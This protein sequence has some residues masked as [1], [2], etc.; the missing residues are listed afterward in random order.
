MRKRK[1]SLLLVLAL[2]VSLVM[3]VPAGAAEVHLSGGRSNPY[4]PG[5]V[6]PELP[7]TQFQGTAARRKAASYVSPEEAA[8][9][10]RDAMVRRESSVTLY[11]AT[12]RFWYQEDD[13]GSLGGNWFDDEFFPM[14]YSQELA[15]GLYD[16]DY[17]KWSW[18]QYQWEMETVS[19]GRYIFT[20]TGISYYT[21]Y[22]EEQ[23]LDKK[24]RA[25]VDALGVTAMSDYEAYKTLYD[26]VTK[27]VTFDYEGMSG[28][29]ENRDYYSYTAYKALMEGTAVCQGYATLY[30]AM[31]RYAKL[32]CRI[33]TSQDH[34]WNI[35]Y[36]KH[37]WYNLDSTWDA[38]QDWEYFLQGSENFTKNVSHISENEYLTDAFQSA[39]PISPKDYDGGTPFHDVDPSMWSY[40]EIKEATE[41]G[42]F[43]GTETWKFDPEAPITRAML[44]T[45]LWRQ[46]GKPTDAPVSPFT[47]LN[48]ADYY[49]Q[50][51]DWAA[52]NGIVTGATLTT[53]EP[54]RE[55]TREEIVTILYRYMNHLG[56]DTTQRDSLSA[57]TDGG[58]IE[59]YAREPMAWAVAS[60]MVKGVGDG[61]LDPKGQTLREQIAAMM[62]R[63]SH[64]YGI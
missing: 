54:D 45:V 42:L 11:I 46:Q 56:K 13:Q 25:V 51:V 1:I 36:L 15:E 52:A 57:F 9:Q 23:A 33:I 37:I 12:D 17:L 19:Q 7:Q 20:V 14:V 18:G 6:Q 5:M 47:D 61:L 29:L 31:C 30:Y 38:G 8:R 26:Y 49:A 48:R 21:T 22:A 59:G 32:P 39:Y 41:K 62:V 28:Y 27:N 24:L 58:L 43:T 2:V 34:A 63:L 55:A 64:S 16:G 4:Y 44:V 35:V 50:A 40:Q 10:L 53:F 60:G 3:A